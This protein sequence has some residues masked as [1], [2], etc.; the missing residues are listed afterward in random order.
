MKD[1]DACKG[2]EAIKVKKSKPHN[3]ADEIPDCGS[4][5]LRQIATTG[6]DYLNSLFLK[7]VANKLVSLLRFLT[8]NLYFVF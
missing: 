5:N 3:L 6:N 7:L 8:R 4:E 1:E 2:F